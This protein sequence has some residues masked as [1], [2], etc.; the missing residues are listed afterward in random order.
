MHDLNGK[1]LNCEKSF[2]K[3]WLDR[4]R[5]NVLDLISVIG[6]GAVDTYLFCDFD[7]TWLESFRARLAEKGVKT[8]VTAFLLKAIS[9]AQAAHPLSRTVLLPWGRTAVVNKIVAGFTVERMINGLP[10]VFFGEILE[11]DKKSLLEISLELKSYGEKEIKDVPQLSI[12]NRFTWMPWLLRRFIIAASMHLPSMRLK[13]HGATFGLSSL[14]K[15]GIRAMIPPCVSTST[16]GVGS[17][18]ERPVVEEGQIVARKIMSVTLNFDHRVIDGAPAARFLSDVRQLI[19]GGLEQYLEVE[20][21]IISGEMEP[22]SE[23]K[24]L[25]GIPVLAVT[26]L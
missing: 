6:R 24:S 7:M 20:R 8:T 14:G 4:N 23:H 18:E 15:Y 13:Y 11:S 2:Y 25:D 5:W 22:S 3:S 12:Q 16:F 19:E 21:K 1:S 17:V 26:A 9:I 10:V